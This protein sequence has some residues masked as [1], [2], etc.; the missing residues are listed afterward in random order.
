MI[1]GLPANLANWADSG[2]AN[3]SVPPPAGKGTIIVTGLTGQLDWAWLPMDTI[4]RPAAPA[5]STSRRLPLT[6]RLKFIV[7]S[8]CI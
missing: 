8:C 1:S 6:A 7:V 4:A 5:L 2:R 3:A